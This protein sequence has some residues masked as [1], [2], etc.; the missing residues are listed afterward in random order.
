MEV[1][2]RKKQLKELKVT[3]PR[4][5]DWVRERRGQE[6]VI[7]NSSER[8]L[9]Q[10]QEKEKFLKENETDRCMGLTTELDHVSLQVYSE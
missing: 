10:P 8:E 7:I 2:A 6:T 5:W 1:S 3:A 4:K 9:P